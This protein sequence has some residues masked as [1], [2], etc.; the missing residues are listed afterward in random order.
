MRIGA[1]ATRSGRRQ[2]GQLRN[3]APGLVEQL[4]RPVALQPLLQLRQVFRMLVRIERHLVRAKVSFDD[5]A[6][7]LARPGPS[8]GRTQH[9][10]RPARPRHVTAGSRLMLDF[11]QVAD[12]RIERRRHGLV[13][14]LGLM[15]FDEIR[16]PAIAAQQLL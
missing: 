13:H 8:L 9:D 6:V 16:S 1:H 12:R 14:R 10:H 3:Q 15:A 7:D 2:R 4:L 5:M 11:L